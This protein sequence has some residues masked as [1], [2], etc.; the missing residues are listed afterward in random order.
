MGKSA[1]HSGLRPNK[2]V[3]ELFFS[4]EASESKK[5]VFGFGLLFSKESNESKK[6]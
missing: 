3:F 5:V 4:K 6:K 1:A 2:V